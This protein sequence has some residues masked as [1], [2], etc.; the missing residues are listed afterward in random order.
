MNDR[1]RATALGQIAA[2]ARLTTIY[3]Y[4]SELCGQ[5]E[6]PAEEQ[7]D[8]IDLP[9]AVL[10]YLTLLDV[11]DRGDSSRV[12]LVGTATTVAVGRNATGDHLAR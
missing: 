3:R 2:D 5:N 4:W 11:I 10:P 7:F 12:R 8:P 6:V 9:A 1:S